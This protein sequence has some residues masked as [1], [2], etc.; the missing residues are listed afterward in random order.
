[1]RALAGRSEISV[2]REAGLPRL[3][4]REALGKHEPKLSRA[5]EIAEAVGLEVRFEPVPSSKRKARSGVEITQAITRIESAR[6]RADDA[7]N[8][9]REANG[10][11]GRLDLND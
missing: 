10:I 8:Q 9:L 2:A 3:A 4:I 1:M 7:I 6:S 5:V 11:L